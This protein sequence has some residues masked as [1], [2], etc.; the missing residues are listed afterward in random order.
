MIS[1]FHQLSSLDVQLVVDKFVYVFLYRDCLIQSLL[2]IVLL[3]LTGS[4]VTKSFTEQLRIYMHA[5]VPAIKGI[6]V[7]FIGTYY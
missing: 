2:Y 6:D 7:V 3:L 1:Y 4:P 5:L